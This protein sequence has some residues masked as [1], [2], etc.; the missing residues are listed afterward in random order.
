M[1][2][3]VIYI[4]ILLVINLTVDYLV[5]F[6]TAR[7]AGI[8]FS[9]IKGLA[10]ALLGS[11]YSVIILFDL[12]KAIFIFSKIAVSVLIVLISFGKRK[13]SE[14]L[15]ILLV[16]Y[17][18]GF[19]FS[20]FMMLVNNI[21]HAD[22]FFIKSGIVYFEFSAVGIVISGILAF[23]LTEILR[24]VFRRGEPEGS[25][26]A[27]IYYGGKVA[28]LKGFTDTGN[29]LSEPISGT[30]VAVTTAD[31]VKRILPPKMFAAIEKMDLS[32]EFG[33]RIVP[34]KSVSGSVLILAF[35][36]DKTLIINEKGE[37]ETEDIMIAV[38]ENVPENT[39]IVGKNI[40]LKEKNK[41]FSEV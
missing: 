32:T 25:F 2:L 23:L 7:L 12:P 14:L 33:L 13:I 21:V 11:V 3:R 19:I 20:G 27:K 37:F 24:R 18:C 15:K 41:I 26:I 16:F 38:S 1:F 39:L 36:P 8:R 31:S 22:S 17:I 40:I 9:R 4:D 6:G 34:C 5:I 29:N 28:V 35:R 10:G 30:P